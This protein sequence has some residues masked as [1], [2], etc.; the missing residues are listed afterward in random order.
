MSENIN[1][2]EMIFTGMF[3]LSANMESYMTELKIERRKIQRLLAQI[4]GRLA[5]SR[6][7]ITYL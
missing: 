1:K 4:E 3:I 7:Q 2:L 6:I 5:E